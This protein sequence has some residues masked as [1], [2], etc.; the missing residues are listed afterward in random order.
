LES[1]KGFKL[2]SLGGGT[3]FVLPKLGN[4]PSSQFSL[5]KLFPTK[6]ESP[7]AKPIDLTSALVPETEQKKIPKV[8]KV[9]KEENFIPQFVDCDLKMEVDVQELLMDT[10]CKQTSLNELKK[11]FKDFKAKKFS[12]IGKILKQKF[13]K[14]KLK[15]CHSYEQKNKIERF[16]FDTPSP[17]EKILAHLNK[18]KK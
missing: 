3:G 7:E 14:K 5:P 6:L 1:S 8:S 11:K 17:D 16:A 9:P 4:L 18:N 12:A 2:P 10:Q 13:D 15:I